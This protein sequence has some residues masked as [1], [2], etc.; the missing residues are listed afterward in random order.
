MA[1]HY[2]GIPVEWEGFLRKIEKDP[3]DNSLVQVNLI[4][5]KS[6][7]VSYSI[8]FSADPDTV[9]EIKTL[10]RDSKLCVAGTIQSASGPGLCV[11]IHLD[12]L[13]VLERAA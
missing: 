2:I 5:D 7:I 12:S 6:R 1:A 4:T 10:Q 3:R 11:T 13:L 9:P 8:W